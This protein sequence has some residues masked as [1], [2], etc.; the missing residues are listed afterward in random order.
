M[1]RREKKNLKVKFSNGNLIVITI[2]SYLSEKFVSYVEELK[3][4]I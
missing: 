3:F 2:K 1:K 4:L